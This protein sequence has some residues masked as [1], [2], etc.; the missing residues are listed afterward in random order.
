MFSVKSL[1]L[2][3]SMTIIY[4][5]KQI[6]ELS[7]VC[8]TLLRERRSV[9]TFIAYEHIYLYSNI[10]ILKQ[11]KDDKYIFLNILVFIIFF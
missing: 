9:A 8:R 11:N 6:L 5:L 4:R 2:S 1:E 3:S 7:Q 10:Y